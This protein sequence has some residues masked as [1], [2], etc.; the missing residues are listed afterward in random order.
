M[1]INILYFLDSLCEA[2]V[3]YQLNT[4]MS[5]SGSG[6]KPASY[7][8]YVSRDLQQIVQLVVPDNRD[9]LVNLASAK[10]VNHVCL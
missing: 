9:G 3:H 8:E 4:G 5:Q 10:Q 2:A 6:R 7:L 1:R